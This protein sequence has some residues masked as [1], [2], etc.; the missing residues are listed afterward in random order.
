[1]TDLPV[2]GDDG[3]ADHLPGARLPAIELPATDGSTVA[4]DR[5]IG[6]TVVFVHPA[7]GGPEGASLDEWTAVPGARGCTPEACGFRDELDAFRAASVDVLGL[8]SQPSARQREAV[9]EL[10]LPY[11]LL[12]DDE[13]RLAALLPTFEFQGERYFKRVTLI[14]ADAT[15]EAAIYPVLP[16][17][18]AARQA[19]NR[20]A[21]RG[22]RP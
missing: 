4:L 15:I 22:P 11:A 17:D 18:Q 8:S 2:S 6:L 13:L 19:L 16:P 5:L 21:D 12:S 10:H 1:V 20:I 3:A 7:I 9:D 14:V